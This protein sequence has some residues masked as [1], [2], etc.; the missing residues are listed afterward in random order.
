M[1]FKDVKIS[2]VVLMDKQIYPELGRAVGVGNMKIP[3]GCPIPLVIE[4]TNNDES[5]HH[6]WLGSSM[7][8]ANDT[9]IV[10]IT[11]DPVNPT[12]VPL[13]FAPGET[14][15][16][17]LDWVVPKTEFYHRLY[18][19]F[20]IWNMEPMKKNEKFGL[21]RGDDVPFEAD[22]NSYWMLIGEQDLITNYVV[23]YDVYELVDIEYWWPGLADSTIQTY[24]EY[25]APYL[26]EEG[27][28]VLNGF[29]NENAK[30]IWV[31]MNVAVA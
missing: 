25:V 27:T 18:V 1:S 28:T 22:G 7:K 12:H 16:V 5:S 11:D 20:S 23:V 29:Y 31:Y 26:A 30:Q 17:S 8:N 21:A 9:V 4:V 3:A 6:V 13:D 2:R 24:V 14:K 15:K 19:R 10:G